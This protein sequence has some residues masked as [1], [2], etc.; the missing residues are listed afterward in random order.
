MPVFIWQTSRSIP[1]SYIEAARIDGCFQVGNIPSYYLP[2]AGSFHD[3]QRYAA[4]DRK[5][6]GFYLPFS[7]YQWWTW[8]FYFDGNLDYHYAGS[9]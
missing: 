9:Y 7:L 1:S 2:Y 5:P 6:E 8:I 4:A 3:N